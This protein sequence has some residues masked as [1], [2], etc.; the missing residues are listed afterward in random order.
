MLQVRLSDIRITLAGPLAE[1][2]ALNQPLRSLGARSDLS[3]CHSV[4][5]SM[6]VRNRKLQEL[7]GA[8]SDARVELPTVNMTDL[9]NE[10]RRRVR[11]WLGRPTIWQAII[12]IA[13]RLVEE[14]SLRPGEVLQA[15]LRAHSK[16]QAALPLDWPDSSLQPDVE[17]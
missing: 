2:K 7:A 12:S 8:L 6:T 1:A 15:Y 4:I 5:H 10:Q 17:N 9:V 16:Q 14:G 3:I 13:D 11:R